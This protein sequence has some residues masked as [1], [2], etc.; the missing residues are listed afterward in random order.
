MTYWGNFIQTHFEDFFHY[1]KH[2]M[3]SLKDLDYLRKFCLGNYLEHKEKLKLGKIKLFQGRDLKSWRCNE[4]S[5]EEPLETVFNDM[6]IAFKYILPVETMKVTRKKEIVEYL[7]YQE[8][9]ETLIYF[10][11]ENIR[12][13]QNFSEFSEKLKAKVFNTPTTLWNI[14]DNAPQGPATKK[15]KCEI[16][17][18]NQLDNSKFEDI[19]TKSYINFSEIY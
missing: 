11:K 10:S 14:L 13:H 1:N 7:T 4:G 8:I 5:I 2:E 19:V 6:K 3:Q 12:Y 18:G 16:D 17:I 15:S 9:S